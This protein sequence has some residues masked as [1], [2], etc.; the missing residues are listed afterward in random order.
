MRLLIAILMM[1]FGAIA[2]VDGFLVQTENV[3]Q[4]VAARIE[5]FGGMCVFG[6]GIIITSLW[7]LESKCERFFKESSKLSPPSEK[8]KTDQT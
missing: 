4:Q 7:I 1:L 5:V 3:W 6:L 8:D 2:T